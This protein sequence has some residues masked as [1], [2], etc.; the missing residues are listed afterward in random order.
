MT[1]SYPRRKAKG[2]EAALDDSLEPEKFP[3][4]KMFQ[5]ITILGPGLLGG[6]LAL[7]LKKRGL[8]R[9]VHAWSRRAETRALALQ[10]DWCDAVF[11][12]AEDA[13]VESELVVICTPVETIVPLLEHVAPSL[14]PGALVT[15]VGSTKSLICRQAR[16]VSGD[17]HFIGSHPMAGSERAGMAHAH[18]DLFKGAACILTPP[19]DAIDTRVARLHQLWEAV[20]M[21]V[22]TTTPEKHD[23]I[24]AHISHLPHLLASSLCSYLADKDPDW[25]QLAGGGLRDTTRVAAGD[26][27]L[28]QQILGQNREEVLRAIDAFEIELHALKTALLEKDRPTVLKKLTRGQQFRDQL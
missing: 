1:S 16:G 23:E 12:R 21:H 9:R 3:L 11:D 18:S 28:W 10:T 17:F 4:R 8:C 22:V 20:G 7:A 26:P 25:K 27:G 2:T 19:D 15:D 6:S 14:A 5:Q 24:V 13:C